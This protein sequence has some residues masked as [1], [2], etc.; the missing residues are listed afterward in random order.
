[1]WALI[2]ALRPSRG[3]STLLLSTFV[4]SFFA[5][6]NNEPVTDAETTSDRSESQIPA[7]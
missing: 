6:L 1:M 2:Y 3:Y 5:L 7:E 4:L